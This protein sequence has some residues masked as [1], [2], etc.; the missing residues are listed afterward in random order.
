MGEE[1]IFIRESLRGKIWFVEISKYVWIAKSRWLIEQQL[2]YKL[3]RKSHVYYKDEDSLNC[4]LSNLVIKDYDKKQEWWFDENG[5]MIV[6][7]T[8][9]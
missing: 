6:R 9:L 8:P 4:I 3:P 7:T 1:N 2:G 5:S